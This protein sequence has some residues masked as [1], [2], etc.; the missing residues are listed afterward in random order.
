MMI[1]PLTSEP[2]SCPLRI[3]PA[4][5]RMDTVQYTLACELEHFE[6]MLLQLPYAQGDPLGEWRR[7]P[8]GICLHTIHFFLLT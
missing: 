2:S 6:G 1:A 8:A 4:G 7:G 5:R 3:F